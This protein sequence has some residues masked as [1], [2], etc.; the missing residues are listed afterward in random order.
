MTKK[1]DSVCALIEKAERLPAKRRRRKEREEIDRKVR[2]WEA[3]GH[4]FEVRT[5]PKTA[6]DVKMR[7]RK[8]HVCRKCLVIIEIEDMI[9]ELL[10]DR[11]KDTCDE[12][13]IANIHEA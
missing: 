1:I 2:E 7:G 9:D 8:L 3:L 11:R 12:R 4:M 10:P 5:V 13:Q 6:E